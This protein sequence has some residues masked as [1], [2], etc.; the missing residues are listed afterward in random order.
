M[1]AWDRSYATVRPPPLG[2][3]R[4]QVLMRIG[5]S[6]P[7][8]STHRRATQT[9]GSTPPLNHLNIAF[10]DEGAV[11][12]R[13]RR[14]VLVRQLHRF[15]GESPQLD[16]IAVPHGFDIDVCV[17]VVSITESAPGR[18]EP[19]LTIPQMQRGY[20]PQRPSV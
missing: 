8:P 20:C 14:I 12:L 15:G 5:L 11:L 19:L 18:R 17:H 13:S 9:F 10:G 6:P 16:Q 7:K 3:V 4:S 1:L 2:N